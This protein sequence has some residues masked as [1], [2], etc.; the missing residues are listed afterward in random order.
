MADRK[1]NLSNYP[2]CWPDGWAR[3]SSYQRKRAH[4]KRYGERITVSAAMNRVLE[5]LSM[6]F[7]KRDDILISTN[8]PTRLDGLPRSDQREPGDPGVAVYWRTT[9]T[10]PM[11]CIAID[12][13]TK[14]ADNLAALAATLEAMRAIER[15]GGAQV[16]ERS[17]RG[18][19]ALTDGT[20]KSWREVLGIIETTV[21]RALVEQVF[22]NRARSAHPDMG[23]SD[24]AM[25]ELNRAREQA[26]A[27]VAQ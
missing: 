13:Y 10:A 26:L 8:I 11:K 23:G 6:M 16:Q 2:L 9:Q 19:T 4:F 5:Q 21:T 18:F 25:A 17:F 15:H 22:R 12:I 1:F 27:E 14:V 20:Q 24:A 7:V 3:T